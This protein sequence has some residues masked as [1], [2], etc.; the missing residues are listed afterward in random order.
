MP[1]YAGFGN[2]ETDAVSYRAMK[3][4]LKNIFIINK[5]SKIHNYVGPD[6]L[7]YDIIHD[8]I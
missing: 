1:F 4:D 3:M 6:V 2:K 5:K 7:T 8:N